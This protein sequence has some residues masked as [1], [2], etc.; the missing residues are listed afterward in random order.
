[1][2]AQTAKLKIL[3]TWLNYVATMKNALIGTK[4][5]GDTHI[6]EFSRAGKS[7]GHRI[8]MLTSKS[9]ELLLAAE[10]VQLE[11]HQLNVPF[12][13]LLLKSKIGIGLLYSLRSFMTLFVKSKRQFDAIVTSSHYPSDV[14]STFLLHLKNPKSKI[15]V[16]HHGI[17]IPPTHGF[18]LRTLSTAYNYLGTLLTARFGDLILVVNKNTKDFLLYFGV[19][20]Q[21]I[22]LTSNGVEIPNNCSLPKEKS[23]DA[24]FLGWLDRRKGIYDL[25]KVWK[26]VCEKRPNSRVTIIGIGPEKER[27]KNFIV[28]MGLKNNITLPG[29]LSG[30][31]KYT[32]LKNSKLFVFPSYIES[33]GIAV[34]EAMAC[35]LPVVAY[36]LPIYRE[37]FEDKLVTAPIGDVN[38]M[39]SLVL[40]LLENPDVGKKIGQ[41]G[42][43]FVRRYKWDTVIAKELSAIVLLIGK[44]FE[45]E[46]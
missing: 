38:A 1:M 28:E 25:I 9:G 11:S 33:W 3:V 40:F 46:D 31:E 7:F 16:Y 42:E 32:L 15:I 5:G 21:K 24:C 22:V 23:L 12:E 6:I 35:G 34:A 44:K 41:V 36:D 4:S 37:V 39:S 14:F 27:A 10:G 2:T 19:K 8:V 45:R 13:N 29:F 17:S 18:I 26:K 30:Y 43:E 20:N